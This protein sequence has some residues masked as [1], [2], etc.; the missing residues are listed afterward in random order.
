MT[1]RPAGQPPPA[2]ARLTV[3]SLRPTWSVAAAMR[4]LRATIVVPVMLWLSFEVIGNIQMAL[5]AVFGSFAALVLTTF[6]GSGGTRRKR[7][8]D[9]RSSAASA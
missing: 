6:G 2:P 1:A 9:S 5:F 3:R 8:W 7:T 4:A